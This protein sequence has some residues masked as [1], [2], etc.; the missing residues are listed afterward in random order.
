MADVRTFG[1]PDRIEGTESDLR[2]ADEVINAWLADGMV[3]ITCDRWQARKLEDAVDV[4]RR[5]FEQPVHLKSRCVSELTYAGYSAAG[6]AEKFTICRDIPREDVRVG[7]GWPCHGPVPWP[8]IEYRRTMRLLTDE[9]GRIG[10]KL[11]H[12]LGIG[13]HLPDFEALAAMTEDGW[14]HMFVQ[15]LPSGAHELSSH[16]L[17]MITVENGTLTVTP[18]E[19]LEFLTNGYLPMTPLEAQ[20][21]TSSELVMSY[22]HEPAFE[23]GLRPVLEPAHGHLH[24]GTYFTDLF[25]RRHPDRAATQRIKAEDRLSVLASLSKRAS[26]GA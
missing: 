20:V 15:R 23:L 5:Y 22:F 19:L 4:G 21:N 18:G 17:L 2:V 11:M 8:S 9:L 12:L 7:A 3:R 25:M 10:E 16:G 13:L 24:Y 6:A 1:L 14:H 26:V